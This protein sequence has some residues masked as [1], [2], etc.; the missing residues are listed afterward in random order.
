[1]VTSPFSFL[2][3]KNKEKKLEKQLGIEGDGRASD[4]VDTRLICHA[5]RLRASLFVPPTITLLPAREGLSDWARAGAC[6]WILLF[7][8]FFKKKKNNNLAL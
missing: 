5:A 2:K 8:F 3:R 7:V 4:G 6:K 1:M